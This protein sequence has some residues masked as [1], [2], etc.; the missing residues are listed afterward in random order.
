M[1][2]HHPVNNYIYAYKMLEKAYVEGKLRAIGV[3]NFPV[4]KLEHLLSECE[5]VPAVMQVEAHPYYPAEKVKDYCE[6]KGIK[7]QAWFPLGHGN[8][9]L[10]NDPVFVS[11]PRNGK[12]AVQVIFAGISRWIRPCSRQQVH[13]HV[14]KCRHL[15]F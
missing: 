10:I 9:D 14:G 6:E 7:L 11:W 2:L 13:G 15:R 1:I 4:E 12:S 5:T 3:S 8:A